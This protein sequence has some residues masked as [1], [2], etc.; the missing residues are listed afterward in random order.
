VVQYDDNFFYC[1]KTD[2]GK[3]AVF[4]RPQSFYGCWRE[5]L[6]LAGISQHFERLIK[7]HEKRNRPY[8][9]KRQK[10]IFEIDLKVRGVCVSALKA[11]FPKQESQSADADEHNDDLKK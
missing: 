8:V 10:G 5:Y 1:D 9:H 7:R 2:N 4:Y 11:R 6:V 3:R